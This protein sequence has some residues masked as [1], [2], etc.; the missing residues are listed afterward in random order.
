MGR[1][2]GLFL[3]RTVTFWTRSQPSYNLKVELSPLCHRSSWESP[4]PHLSVRPS[5]MI[6]GFAFAGLP[7]LCPRLVPFHVRPPSLIRFRVPV[8]ADCTFAVVP[9]SCPRLV[10]FSLTI[11]PLP[12]QH[13]FFERANYGWV[14]N[15]NSTRAHLVSLTPG[16]YDLIRKETKD[17]DLAH[18]DLFPAEKNKINWSVQ[19]PCVL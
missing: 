11:V 7:F 15:P 18:L 12:L 19:R 1:N 3:M 16:D 4:R 5:S 6:L 17:S 8:W 10:L 13:G 2:A 9:F 14:T